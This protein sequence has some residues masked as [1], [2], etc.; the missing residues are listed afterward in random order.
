M[1][2]R[3][4]NAA[5]LQE[6]LYNGVLRVAEFADEIEP[7]AQQQSE[8]EVAGHFLESSGGLTGAKE[9]VRA[10]VI[11]GRVSRLRRTGR[12]VP[13]AFRRAGSREAPPSK[14]LRV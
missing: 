1:S 13:G 4:G 10:S 2:G 14:L 11:C 7:E 12:I 6:A 9:A 8:D 3:V 5:P